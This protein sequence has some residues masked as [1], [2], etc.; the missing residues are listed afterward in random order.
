MKKF[1]IT[2]MLIFVPAFLISL[3]G[4]GSES[5]HSREAEDE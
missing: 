5:E 1:I 2:F 4:T 3:A